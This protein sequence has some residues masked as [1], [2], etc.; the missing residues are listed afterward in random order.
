MTDRPIPQ[1]HQPDNALAITDVGV[2]IG[3]ARLL[4][5]VSLSVRPGEWVGLI[6]PNGA[7]KS[8]LLRAVMNLVRFTGAV[9]LGG[10]VV[11]TM[12]ARERGRMIALVPQT[13]TVPEGISVID[14]VYLGRTPHLG[15]LARTGR[16]DDD[17]VREVVERLGLGN[18]ANRQLASLSGGERQRVFV[19]RALAQEPQVLLLDEPTTAL[20]IGHQQD[21]LE[22]LDRTRRDTGLSVLATMHDL[23]MAGSY[24]D[25]IVLLHQGRVM[26]SGT[27]AEVLTTGLLRRVYGAQVEVLRPGPGHGPVVVGVRG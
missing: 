20:D 14:Y 25:H 9:S 24:S 15:L 7:G 10:R 17:V 22:L 16:A 8:T 5:A 27:A 26:R 3:S 23:T 1:T 21:V 12:S 11:A 18:L 13:P 6:G 19:A 2:A 4:D